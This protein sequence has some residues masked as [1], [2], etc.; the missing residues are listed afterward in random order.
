M[1]YRRLVRQWYAVLWRFLR[2]EWRRVVE[3]LLWRRVAP[4]LVADD[5]LCPGGFGAGCN[6][7]GP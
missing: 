5:L 6:R 7:K 4:L 3:N 1:L 2:D